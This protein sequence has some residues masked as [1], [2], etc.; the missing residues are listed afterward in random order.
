MKQIAVLLLSAASVFAVTP[1]CTSRFTISNTGSLGLNPANKIYNVGA[2]PPI[3]NGGCTAWTIIYSANGF[4]QITLQVETS[5]TANGV[6]VAWP[7][8]VNYGQIPWTATP[9][10]NQGYI[11]LTGTYNYLRLNTPFYQGF[12]TI[13]VQMF[14]W[15]N[16]ANV[17]SIVNYATGATGSFTLTTTG[18]SGASTYTGGVLNIPIYSGGASPGGSTGALQYNNAGAFGGVGLGTTT[19][20]YHGNAAGVGTFAPVSLTADISNILPL[21]NGGTGT[22]T[23]SLVAGT[24]ITITGTWPNQT[25]TA[26]STGATA[27]SALT[28]GTN[29]NAGSFL[30]GNGTALGVTGTGTITANYVPASAGASPTVNGQVAFDTTALDLVFGLGGSTV[31]TVWTTGAKTA[32]DCGIWTSATH[33]TDGGS[34]CAMVSGSVTASTIPTWTGTGTLL[35]GSGKTLSGTGAAVATTTGSH[36]AGNCTNWDSNGNVVDA[37]APCGSGGSGF[38]QTFYHNGSSVTQRTQF[39]TVDSA[40]GNHAVTVTFAD[41]SSPSRTSAT[42]D[43]AVGPSGALDCTTN[44]YC[45]VVTAVVPLKASA[46]VM[47]GV[48]KFSQLQ[49]TILTVSTLPTCNS[50]FEGQFE[51]VSDAA[52]SPVYNATVTGGGSVH[53]PVYCNGTTWVNH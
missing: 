27:F 52:A 47:T 29:T 41:S 5:A 37:G 18:T 38:Y 46:N 21:A 51:G 45:D 12:G 34:P 9:T 4:S 22:A 19:T 7:G 10:E 32:N 44:P 2:T 48:N 13:Y 1:D 23:P 50:S 17:G 40:G 26:S 49:V 11:N 30:F 14:G 24:N 36:T 6:F 15:I 35:A 25:I 53:I 33:L 16:P 28:P 20:V 8:I 42:Y 43:V 31:N 39:N 3:P